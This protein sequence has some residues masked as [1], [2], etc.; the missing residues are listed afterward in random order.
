MSEANVIETELRKALFKVK[1]EL[2]R[3]AV[4][5]DSMAKAEIWTEMKKL[6]QEMDRDESND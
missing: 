4:S 3:G 1:K 6:Q 5:K 2:D